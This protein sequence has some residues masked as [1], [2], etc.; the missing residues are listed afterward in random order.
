[1]AVETWLA[2]HSGIWKTDVYIFWKKTTRNS[3]R[4]KEEKDTYISNFTL[5][6]RIHNQIDRLRVPHA[7]STNEFY[8]WQQ[9]PF[10]VHVVL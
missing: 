8:E 9:I 6:S 3:S 7:F 10:P 5:I 2:K 1:M 4:I